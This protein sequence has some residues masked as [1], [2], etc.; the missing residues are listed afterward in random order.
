MEEFKE[1]KWYDALTNGYFELTKWV[2]YTEEEMKADES[3]R[4]TGGRTVEI[5]YKEACNNWWN[6]LDTEDKE[7]IKTMP[8]FDADIFEEITG[9]R[10]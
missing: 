1:T 5:P 8:N 7:V 3:K 4:N 10:V 9:V 2:D 6:S